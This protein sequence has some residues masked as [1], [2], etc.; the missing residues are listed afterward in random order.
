MRE[1]NGKNPETF[2]KGGR[3]MVAAVAIEQDLRDMIPRLLAREPAKVIAF[4]TAATPRSAAN[5][6]EGLHLPQV[7]HF[8]MLARQYPELRAKVLEWLDAS[9]GDSGEDP[10][11]V[12]NEIHRLIVNART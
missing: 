11:R 6:Q 8:I 3:L 10:S 4:K 1:R 9:T 5:W 12:L 2:G 7:P